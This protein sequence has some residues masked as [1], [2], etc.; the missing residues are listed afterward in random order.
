[1]SRDARPPLR[2]ETHERQPA[3][4]T[5]SD[6]RLPGAVA[7][8]LFVALWAALAAVLDSPVLPPP[9]EVAARFASLAGP[10][11]AGH[12]FASLGRVLIA[13]AAATALALPLGIAIGRIRVMREGL[14]PLV[15]LLYPVPKIALLPLVFLF[16][17]VGEPARVALVWL[18]LFFQVVVA[19][20]DAAARVPRAYQTAL[21][22][23][24]GGRRAHLR[25][26]LL[27]AILPALLTA[28]RIG[29]GTALAVLFFAETFFTDR[30][31]G[32]FIV[33]SWMKSAY[34]D[35]TAGIVAIGLLGLLLFSALDL[36]QR[37]LCRWQRV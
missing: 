5:H 15:Y 20:R 9:G 12:A 23:L 3:G 17:G 11:L 26:V 32:F 8:V 13:L 10:A 27:P 1:M 16:I 28:L 7:P 2:A 22:A 25:F 33:D 4:A 14:T 34:V 35:M 19:V 37:R 30:G 31:L 18:V 29:S 24:G 36:A 6:R 21:T